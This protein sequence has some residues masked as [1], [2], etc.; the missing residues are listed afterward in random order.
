MNYKQISDRVIAVLGLQDDTDA[1]EL[2]L[3]QDWVFEGIGDIAARTRAGT[4]VINLKLTADTP[5]HDMSNVIISLLD[6]E[7]SYGFLPRLT[8][9]DAVTAQGRLERGYAYE[10]P[11]L[12]FSPVPTEEMFFKAYGVFR[13]QRMM[14]D[15]DTPATPQFGNL[16]PEF[17]PTIVTYALW[18]GGEYTEHEQSGGGERWRV[19]YEGQDGRGGEIS[20]IKAILS[21]RVTPAGARRRY[22]VGQVG[23][24]SGP[25]SYLG[26]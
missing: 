12:W 10:E 22:P 20:K 15:T 24:L 5:V 2:A 11:L 1:P 14:L 8:R 18:K 13:P 6:L 19:Q 16:A 4:R 9:Q 25:L 3:V 7:D 17:H 21:K 23:G 26:G